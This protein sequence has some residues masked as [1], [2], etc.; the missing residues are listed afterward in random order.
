MQYKDV[1]ISGFFSLESTPKMDVS[2]EMSVLSK[3]SG[4]PFVLYKYFKAGRVVVLKALDEKHRGDMVCEEMLRKEFEIGHSLNHPCIREYYDFTMI[5]G[6]GYCIEMEWV[7][8]RPLTDLLHVCQ[9]DNALCDK[10]VSQLLDAVRLIHLKQVVHRD[11]KPSNILVTNNGNNLKLID[12]SLSDS[13]SHLVLKGNAGTAMYASPEQLSCSKSDYR[14]DIYSIGVILSEMSNRRHYRKVAEKCMRNESSNRY[15]SIDAL[16]KALFR[17]F[18]WTRWIVLSVLAIGF[19][20]V[21]LSF[22]R[23]CTRELKS[24]EPPENEFYLNGKDIDSIFLRAT[25]AIEEVIPS[26]ED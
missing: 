5:P 6:I 7:D 23:G 3:S 21:V 18:P 13:D 11:L 17:P 4:S 25:D 16:E 24:S 14:S 15:G 9:N 8:G 20:A 12:F 26:Q 10:L 1:E 19:V 22:Y 2:R